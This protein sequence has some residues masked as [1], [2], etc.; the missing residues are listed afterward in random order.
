MFTEHDC[1]VVCI[2][3][4]FTDLLIWSYSFSKCWVA[5][6]ASSICSQKPFQAPINNFHCS[7]HNLR[8]GSRGKKRNRQKTNQE[9]STAPNYWNA[10]SDNSDINRWPVWQNMEGNLWW[11]FFS[12]AEVRMQ[13][14]CAVIT[15]HRRTSSNKSPLWCLTGKLKGTS[16]KK[17]SSP[18]ISAV[19]L[20][21]Y[22]IS[23]PGPR[24]LFSSWPL[25]SLWTEQD[26]QFFFCKG[27]RREKK[28]NMRLVGY[29]YEICHCVEFSGM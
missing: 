20:S 15:S 21:M 27:R 18:R 4:K 19:E 17:C 8:H 1:T 3:T 28:M 16:Y 10:Y 12:P 6:W 5:R 26:S 7:L 11:T 22:N 25:T 2:S 9:K 13:M 24:R 23:L 14:T 29:V